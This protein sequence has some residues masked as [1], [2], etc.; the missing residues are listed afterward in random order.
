MLNSLSTNFFKS[1]I[2]NIDL[3]SGYGATGVEG[4]LNYRFKFLS[5]E[6]NKETANKI[7]FEGDT[8]CFAFQVYGIDED[9]TV[10]IYF[11]EPKSGKRFDVERIDRD[12]ENFRGF[13][14]IGT[15]LENFLTEEFE[16]NWI[17]FHLLVT[18]DDKGIIKE[19]TKF[20]KF[21]IKIDYGK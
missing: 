18:F 13:S 12:G 17:D 11:V 4:D 9:Q 2:S 20:G 16:S 21:H 15:I 14:L 19:V 7:Y 8:L 3:G 10:K 5:K 1:G 6:S